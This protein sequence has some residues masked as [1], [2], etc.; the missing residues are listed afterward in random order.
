[1]LN[2]LAGFKEDLKTFL[3]V[4]PCTWQP[5]YLTDQIHLRYLCKGS[6]K[7]HHIKLKLAQWYIRT[8][9]LKQNVDDGPIWMLDND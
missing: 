9:N 3:N 5:C 4:K 8:C 2:Y 7:K 6:F 1:M